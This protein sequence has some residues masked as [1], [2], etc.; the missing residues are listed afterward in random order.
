[1]LQESCTKM[2]KKTSLPR[3]SF[4]QKEITLRPIVI[5][6]EDHE[7]SRDLL[8][9]I[10]TMKGCNVLEAVNLSHILELANR[11]HPDLIMINIGRPASEGLEALRQMRNSLSLF[12]VPLI[13]TSADGRASFHKDVLATG[14]NQLLVK[15]IDFDELDSLLEQS[16]FRKNTH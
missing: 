8:K 9:T 15:P 12:D 3:S 11:V 14:Y 13:V 4:T 16:L 7:D 10:L 5:I 6:A 2:P 1:M